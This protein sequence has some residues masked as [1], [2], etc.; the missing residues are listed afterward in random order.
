MCQ[1]GM[2]DDKVCLFFLLA[3]N[4]NGILE[5][6][7][8]MKKSYVIKWKQLVNFKILVTG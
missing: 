8:S 5:R 1:S 3:E 6:Q 4:V 2:G 7:W